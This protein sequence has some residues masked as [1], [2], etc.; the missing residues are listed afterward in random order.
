MNQLSVA[1]LICKKHLASGL[2]CLE[3]FQRNYVEQVNLSVFEDGSLGAGD[4]EQIRNTFPHARIF[5][6]T[7]MD[8]R[9]KESLGN[10]PNCMEQRLENPMILKLVDIPLCM[11]R[12]F[13]YLDTDIYFLREFELNQYSNERSENFVFMQDIE[14]G[15]S[16]GLV[17][18]V[19]KYGL[20]LPSRLNAGVYSIPEDGYD[21]DFIEWFLGIRDF[22]VFPDVIE[23][24]CWAAMTRAKRT[25]YFDPKRLSCATMDFRLGPQQVG[26]HF[27]GETKE[28]LWKTYL[29]EE[30]LPD[31]QSRPVELSLVRAQRLGVIEIIRV[32]MRNRL[33]RLGICRI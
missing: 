15:Y 17:K 4:V 6:K 7:E 33:R 1:T 10:Y 8:S 24:T 31:E 3:S 14:Q 12:P 9:V 13:L 26:V 20:T 23:Q 32:G 29:G 30:K 28:V 27:I 18:I 2:S 5:T 19:Y 11:E 21:I 22:Y 16:A 25:L